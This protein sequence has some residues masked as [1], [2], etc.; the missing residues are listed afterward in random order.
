MPSPEKRRGP[1]DPKNS[2]TW[3]TRG[4]VAE[5]LGCSCGT[6]RRFE[7]K[8]LHPVVDKNGI[9]RFPPAEVHAQ[10][11]HDQRMP[12]GPLREQPSDGEIA[13]A[14]FHM[15]AAEKTR[16]EVVIALR[17]TPQRVD[18]LWAEYSIGYEAAAA[19]RK[20][21]QVRKETEAMLHGSDEERR[22]RREE[23]AKRH[24]EVMADIFAPPKE[25]KR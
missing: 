9:H 5:I 18:D 15:F 10:R 22:K 24:S 13:A 11:F 16:T 2:D 7:G 6:I 21:E 1:P 19:K 12:K 4:E 20:Q 8:K 14:A 23:S 17:I 3:Y 25:A